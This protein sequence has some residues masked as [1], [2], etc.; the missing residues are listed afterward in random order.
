M[1]GKKKGG[2]RDANLNPT[3]GDTSVVPSRLLALFER[4]E[5]GARDADGVAE[6]NDEETAR[7]WAELDA[8]AAAVEEEECGTAK[9][10]LITRSSP[11]QKGQTSAGPRGF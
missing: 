1:V 7:G 4:A 9:D 11:Q 5:A 8:R 2:G 10:M 6:P 3:R